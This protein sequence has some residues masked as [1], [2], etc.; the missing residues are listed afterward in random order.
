MNLAPAVAG[1][2]IR[3]AAAASRNRALGQRLQL[4]QVAELF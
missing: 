3:T 4:Q 1:K 2:N